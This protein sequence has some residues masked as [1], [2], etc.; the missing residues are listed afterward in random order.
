MLIPFLDYTVSNDV[1]DD[2][3]ACNT[4][5]NDDLN[6]IIHICGTVG[7]LWLEL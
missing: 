6:M 5:M 7:E 3:P 4:Y 2:N 1:H